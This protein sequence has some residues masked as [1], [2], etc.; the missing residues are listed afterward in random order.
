[1][2][3]LFHR[4]IGDG[5]FNED[6]GAPVVAVGIVVVLFPVPGVDEGQAFPIG[7]AAF[8][9]NSL[10]QE[11]RDG[12]H[13][14]HQTGHIL[15]NVMVDPLEDI[16]PLR[17]SLALAADAI[18]VVDMAAA[19]GLGVDGFTLQGENVGDFHSGAHAF[20]NLSG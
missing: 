13:V 12:N 19:V 7:V 2:L 6:E 15:E 4:L 9:D 17:F 14:A 8:G 11:R 1:M 3:R 20:H 16:P 18:G 10:S 5:V